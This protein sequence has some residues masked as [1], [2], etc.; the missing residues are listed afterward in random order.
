MLGSYPTAEQLF[1]FCLPWDRSVPDVRTSRIGN[2]EFA[3]VSSSNDLRFQEAVFLRP[4]QIKGYKPVGPV[5]GIVALVV[6]FGSNCFARSASWR[7]AH[8]QQ[9]TSSRLRTLADGHPTC[10]ASS[11]RLLIPMKLDCTRRV[12]SGE[13]P[14]YRKV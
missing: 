5:A 3:F 10:L 12:Q 11:S 7:P 13:I 6:G 1:R 8:S 2:N 4:E 14:H 9:R